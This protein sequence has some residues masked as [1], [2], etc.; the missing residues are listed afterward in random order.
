MIKY[1]KIKN[2]NSKQKSGTLQADSKDGVLVG[3]GKE[4]EGRG[5]NSLLIN[6]CIFTL[7]KAICKI[8]LLSCFSISVLDQYVLVL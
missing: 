4:E 7:K 1:N 5:Q 8:L 3:R 6:L 2:R